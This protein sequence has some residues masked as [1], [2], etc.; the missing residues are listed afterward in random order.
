MT[1]RS[2]DEFDRALISAYLDD[3]LT[4][5]QSQ[6]VRLHLEDCAESRAIFE[7]LKQIREAT[8]STPFAT[9]EDDQ[10]DERPRTPASGMLRW[11]GFALLGVA[12]IVMGYFLVEAIGEAGTLGAILLIG[13]YGGGLLVFL[14]VLIDRLKTYKTD[15]Y[16]GVEK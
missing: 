8:M 14:S 4:Q 11:A 12:L 13:F 16:R 1:E 3:E 9:V 7:E 15:R 2:P 6:R 10:W 5:Q